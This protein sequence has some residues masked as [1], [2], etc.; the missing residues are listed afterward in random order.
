MKKRIGILAFLAAVAGMTALLPFESSDVAQLVPVE[1]LVVSMDQGEVVLDGGAC[2]G[3]GETWDAAW[4]DLKRGAEGNV[5]LGTAEQVI[6]TGAAVDL[7]PQAAWC[8]ELRPAAVICVSPGPAPEPEEAAAYL[9]AHNGGV[10]LQQVRAALLQEQPVEL[11]VLVETEGGLR[12][13][14]TKHR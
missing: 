1:A 12:L 13:Y 7:L 11:P 10:T 9:S 2:Q 3:R 5:F 4:Q 6:L 8:E 14:G